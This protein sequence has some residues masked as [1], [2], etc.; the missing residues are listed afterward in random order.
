MAALSGGYESFFGFG[1]RPFSLTPDPYFY[2]RSRSHARA[3]DALAFSLRRREPFVLVSG[4][5]GVGKS[6]LCR[7]LS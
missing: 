3:F 2:F 6:T 5:A 4:D 1:E 7:T